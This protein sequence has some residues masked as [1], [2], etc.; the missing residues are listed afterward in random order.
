MN[1]ITISGKTLSE[2]AE[3]ARR[4]DC[5]DRMVPSDLRMLVASHRDADA[6]IA[7][8]EAQV[9]TAREDA[10]REAPERVWIDKTMS[11]YIAMDFPPPPFLKWPE[12]VRA[13]L[14]DP[15]SDPRVVALVKAVAD[16]VEAAGGLG[17]DICYFPNACESNLHKHAYRIGADLSAALA[18]L[19]DARG[20]TDPEAHEFPRDPAE[21]K[22]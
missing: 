17:D 14:C 21:I 16:A 20:G 10:L 11:G 19:R 15:L 8:L 13:D 1:A 6:K 12:Y 9:V 2:W 5:L 18:A 7:A 3:Y 22:T 4:D